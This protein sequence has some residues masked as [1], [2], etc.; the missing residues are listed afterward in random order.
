VKEHDP[1]W[2]QRLIERLGDS[3]GAVCAVLFDTDS[4]F[5]E[6][7]Q[8]FQRLSGKRGIN[9]AELKSLIIEGFWIGLGCC[10]AEDD[11]TVFTR[12]F[13]IEGVRALVSQA[14]DSDRFEVRAP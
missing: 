5:Q 9:E 3:D 7:L 8:Q 6:L 4:R 1:E 14:V 13:D 10:G 12:R 11:F 2:F